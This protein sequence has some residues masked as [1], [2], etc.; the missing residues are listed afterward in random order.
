MLDRSCGS[1]FCSGAEGSQYAGGRC[2]TC[3][4][5]ALLGSG[6]ILHG[7]AHYPMMCQHVSSSASSSFGIWG[8]LRPDKPHQRN[9][10]AAHRRCASLLALMSQRMSG[11]FLLD[12]EPSIE[13]L[14]LELAWST[15]RSVTST[16]C[17][18]P[19][20]S[21]DGCIPP[22]C[23]P[24]SAWPPCPLPA[25]ILWCHERAS[26]TSSRMAASEC[27]GSSP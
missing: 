9:N 3:F 17:S 11:W 14:G 7:L 13:S 24:I 20:A 6:Y 18:T 15:M 12:Q 22:E 25:Y 10:V 2:G 26:A 21:K 16:P 27:W 8:P 5:S 23:V 19:H 1:I 4:R